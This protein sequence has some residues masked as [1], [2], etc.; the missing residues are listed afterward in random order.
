MV[1]KKEWHPSLNPVALFLICRDYGTLVWATKNLSS[2]ALSICSSYNHSPRLAQFIVCHVLPYFWP[3]Q[4]PRVSTVD[5]ASPSH[6]HASGSDRL[7]SGTLSLLFIVQA[8]NKRYTES[9]QSCNFHLKAIWNPHV[10]FQVLLKD[11]VVVR[12]PLATATMVLRFGPLSTWKKAKGSIFDDCVRRV[13][14]FSRGSLSNEFSI[15]NIKPERWVGYKQ[16]LRISF[17]MV[18]KP[19]LLFNNTDLV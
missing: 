17:V 6:L 8:S 16:C 7:P 4:C 2:S 10:W 14:P 3:F 15:T 19:C 1:P 11:L 18:Q 9:S 13:T 5:Q 12:S